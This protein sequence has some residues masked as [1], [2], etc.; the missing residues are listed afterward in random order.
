MSSIGDRLKRTASTRALVTL[1]CVASVACSS[2]SNNNGTNGAS[3]SS[4]MS[5]SGGTPPDNTP[6][7][8]QSDK[9]Y[10][11]PSPIRRLTRE[12]YNNTTHDLFG[13]TSQPAKSFPEEEL[14]LGFPNIAAAQSVSVLLIEQY[15]SAAMALASKAAAD[16]P[17]LM[18]CDPSGTNQAACARSFVSG[19]GLKTY[20]RPLTDGEVDRLVGFFQTSATSYDVATAAKMTV[21]AMLQT[22]SFLYKVEPSDQTTAGR[23]H[24]L[25]GY[26]IATRL[27]YLLWGSMPDKDLFDAAAKGDLDKDDG[28]RSQAQRL[29][30]APA[31][32]A[33]VATFFSHWLDL[34]KIAVVD[35]DAAKYPTLTPAMRG[36]LRKQDDAF[37]EDVVFSGGKLDALL[38]GNYTYMNKELADFYGVTGPTGTALE[39]FTWPDGSRRGFMGMAGFLASSAK[40]D[41]S[42]PVQRGMFVRERFFCTTPPPPPANVNTTVPPATANE[43]TRERFA[44]HESDPS[45]AGCH[46][47]MD[48]IGLGMEHFDAIGAW[49]DDENGNAVDASGEIVGADVSGAF[50]GLDG[51]T[52]KLVAS[53]D[54]RSCVVKQWFRFG[55]GRQE[56]SIDKCALD[57][58][59]KAFADSGGDFPELLLALTQTDAFLNRTEEGATP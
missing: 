12:E 42:S 8:C 56:A 39:K 6:V 5:G 51:L 53:A 18:G 35:K 7:D 41:Q 49:R 27:S 24:R 19:F 48:P 15:E 46:L 26:E 58:L 36:L 2:G 52:D 4:G 44:R 20:R 11:G 37:L 22:A 21:Q 16:V 1:V 28:V 38:Q 40:S 33:Q 25:T 59:G 43:T 23:V 55:Y 57:N 29:L 9:T 47:L 34:N 45:C 31:A 17:G 13:D 30:A 10:A 32:K 54:L 50:D 14:T 3:G